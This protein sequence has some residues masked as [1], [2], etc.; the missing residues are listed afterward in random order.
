MPGL[1]G[2][3][4]IIIKN[5][6]LTLTP[7]VGVHILAALLVTIAGKKMIAPCKITW[8]KYLKKVATQKRPS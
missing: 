4:K 3:G 8:S 7:P 2:M 6:L 1:A 5:N